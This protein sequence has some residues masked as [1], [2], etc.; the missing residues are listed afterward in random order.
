MNIKWGQCIDIPRLPDFV[1][2]LSHVDVLIKIS[3]LRYKNTQVY[4]R[5]VPYSSPPDYT[6]STKI[7]DFS[8]SAFICSTAA[9]T[10]PK[11]RS[12]ATTT[13][14]NN[15]YIKLSDAQMTSTYFCL[16]KLVMTGF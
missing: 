8:V 16:T 10:L 14:V 15:T 3:E 2:T 13:N 11:N 5:E 1:S 6:K 4:L 7:L 12:L 9:L